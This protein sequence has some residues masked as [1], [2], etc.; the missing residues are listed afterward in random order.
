M[1]EVSEEDV[2]KRLARDN[3]WWADP[4]GCLSFA[5]KLPKR[6][7]FER[8]A[9]LAENPIECTVTINSP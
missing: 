1:L 7:Y 5:R 6:D 8:F 3:P 4:H 2:A 9:E